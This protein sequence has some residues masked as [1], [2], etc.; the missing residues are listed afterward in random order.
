MKF[1]L[2]LV[3]LIGL[4]ALFVTKFV[5]KTPVAAVRSSSTGNPIR[6]YLNQNYPNAV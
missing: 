4:I 5:G 1:D 3:V 6:D 2:S